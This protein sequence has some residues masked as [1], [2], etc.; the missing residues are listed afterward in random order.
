MRSNQWRLF[1]FFIFTDCLSMSALQWSLW[2]I[3]NGKT[4]WMQRVTVQGSE[5][6]PLRGVEGGGLS[7]RTAEQG[8]SGYRYLGG[9]LQKF[10]AGMA[11]WCYQNGGLG[12]KTT[13]P[14]PHCSGYRLFHRGGM[15]FDE[16]VPFSRGKFPVAHWWPHTSGQ[17]LVA[18]GVFSCLLDSRPVIGGNSSLAFPVILTVSFDRRGFSLWKHKALRAQGCTFTK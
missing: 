15:I 17:D 14:L 16:K 3:N 9:S 1:G 8:S 13:S 18:G 10:R 4:M 7:S 5:E 11:T 6:Q 2:K 12:G